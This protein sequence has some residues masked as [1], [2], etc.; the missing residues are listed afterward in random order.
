MLHATEL[1]GAETYDA[2]GN[3]LGRLTELFIDPAEQPNRIGRLLLGRGKF[4]PLVARYDQVA[5]VAPGTVRLNCGERALETYSPNEGWLAVRKDLLDQQIID[6]SGRKVVRVNDVDLAEQR[7]NGTV[8][9]RITQVDVG[10][11]GA[12]RRLLQGLVSSTAIRRLQEKL[13][14]KL[15]RWEFVNLIEPDPLRRVKLRITHEKLENLH[16]ADLADI[17]EDISASERQ[18]IIAS[19]DEETAAAVLAE[20]DA[21][22]TTQIVEKLDPEKAAEILEEMAPDAAADVLADLSP[23]TSQE[24]L[25]EMPGKEA[26]EVRQLMQFE[27][28][29]AG[30]MM[31]P[32]FVFV[33]ESATRD[34]VVEWIRSKDLNLDQLDAVV[35]IDNA[36]GFSGSVPL[37]RLLLGLPDQ[38]VGQMKYEPL[39]WVPPDAQEKEVFELFDKY[40]LRSL[41]V[42]DANRRPLGTITVDDVVTRL[43]KII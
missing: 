40:N 26:K 29:T 3:F 17:M 37:G 5:F 25:E 8:E 9:L 13:P 27:E 12:A 2:H 43:V 38:P 34:E 16:P 19:L 1:M 20:L 36:A 24:L 33:G 41:T 31:N 18:S 21:R 30:G 15:I 4:Q 11:T 6:T 10:L 7:M 28:N 42:V 39:I 14:A 23:E 32:D 35:L 22:L